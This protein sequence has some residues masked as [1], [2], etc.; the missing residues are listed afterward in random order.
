MYRLHKRSVTTLA[1]VTATLS[2]VA[3][4]AF[5]GDRI[6]QLA[7]TVRNDIARRNVNGKYAVQYD[8]VD[9]VARMRAIAFVDSNRAFFNKLAEFHEP[10]VAKRGKYLLDARL[11]CRCAI[12]ILLR[13][14]LVRQHAADLKA[15]NPKY[16]KKLACDSEE[17]D[18]MVD[19]YFATWEERTSIPLQMLLPEYSA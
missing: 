15:I 18:A 14:D 16:G 13:R 3:T 6:K 12:E 2:S 5:N 8:R 19:N 7:R 4:S 11:M 9:A 10:V 17:I 1:S